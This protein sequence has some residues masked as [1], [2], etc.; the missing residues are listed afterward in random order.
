MY[1]ADLYNGIHVKK[2]KKKRDQVEIGFHL[3]F[4]DAL[5]LTKLNGETI[6]T[7]IKVIFLDLH[8]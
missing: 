8:V 3:I 2:K 5:Q 4:V 6:Y 7:L 1:K